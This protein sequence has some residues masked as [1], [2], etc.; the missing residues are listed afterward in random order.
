MSVEGNKEDAENLINKFLSKIED[1]II[2]KYERFILDE[3]KKLCEKAGN[4][5]VGLIG[6]PVFHINQF[7]LIEA[8]EEI[9][10]DI[11]FMFE[12]RGS[13]MER[14]HP[15]PGK[16]AG[17]MVYRLSRSHI[18]HL[19]E[20]CASCE[21]QCASNLNYKFAV[22]CAWEYVGIPYLRV[23]EEIRRELLYSLALRHVNQETLALVF[24]IILFNRKNP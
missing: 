9:C 24:D 2:Q 13:R 22:K 16:I 14:S 18:V 3:R 15:S 7:S 1:V 23:K 19:L 12:R 17:V 4:R 11:R 20:G 21:V 5:E 6:K 10:K 8:Y